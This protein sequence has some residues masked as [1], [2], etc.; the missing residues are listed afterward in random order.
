MPLFQ[1][2]PSLSVGLSDIDEQ[3]KKLLNL[4][5]DLHEAMKQ[6]KA[7]Q[8]LMGVATA[9]RDY[10]NTHFSHE[11]K[12]MRRYDYPDLPAHLKLHETFVAKLVKLEEDMAKDILPAVTV[13]RYLTDWYL[14][15]IGKVDMKYAEHIRAKNG[16]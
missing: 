15:H 6:G 8:A 13:A 7:K 3:H 5:N 1:W 4:I 9:L 10:V 14:D 11:E 2:N 12:L 16:K